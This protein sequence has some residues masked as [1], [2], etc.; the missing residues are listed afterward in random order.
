M[1]SAHDAAGASDL[2]DEMDALGGLMV[3]TNRN[4]RG[5]QL[6]CRHFSLSVVSSIDFQQRSSTDLLKKY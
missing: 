4:A 2:K 1:A 3:C 6:E 5:C